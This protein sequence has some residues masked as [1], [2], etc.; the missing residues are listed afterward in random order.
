MCTTYFKLLHN[1]AVPSDVINFVGLIVVTRNDDLPKEKFSG[2][3]FEIAWRLFVGLFHLIQSSVSPQN[4]ET[5]VDAHQGSVFMLTNRSLVS[6]PY[7]EPVLF[8]IN[9]RFR[10]IVVPKKQ[11]NQI[12]TYF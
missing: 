6:W 7:F 12:T 5:L 2:C 9:T 3:R 1:V 4:F 11:T 8:D 10:V